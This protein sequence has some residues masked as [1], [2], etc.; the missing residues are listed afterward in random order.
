MNT[1]T[2]LEAITEQTMVV[3]IDVSKKDHLAR[4]FDYRGTELCKKIEFGNSREGFCSFTGRIE[5][6]KAEHMKPDII[7][8]LEP[9][10]VYGHVLISYLKDKGYNVVYTLG[11]QVKRAKELEDNSPAKNDFKDAKTIASLVNSGYYFDIRTYSREIAELKE[12]TGFA[13]QLTKK[14]TRV[15]CQIKDCLTEY[16]PEFTTAFKSFAYSGRSSSNKTALVTLHLFPL[17]CQVDALTAEEIVEAWR[18]AGVKKGIGIKKAR[19]LKQLAAGTVGLEATESVR[20]KFRGLM[21]ELDLLT[22]QEAGIWQR[23][24]AL[25]E[26]NADFQAIN[27]IPYLSLRLAANLLAEVGDFRDFS[28]PQQLVRLAGLN[29]KESSSGKSRGR[30]EITKRGR[31]GLRRTLYFIILEQLKNAAP[32]WHQLHRHNT[33]R[34]D[35][36]LKCIC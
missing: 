30:S 1:N 24:R 10:G 36:P 11:M 9:T 19:Q 32:G 20:I 26:G 35:N 16:F 15:K 14:L 31:A 3:G 29:L 23:V 7:I 17:P 4:V 21:D 6:L 25:V 8:G 34:K 13:Y 33:T 2:K 5:A 22:G 28:H 27:A 18:A 12:A